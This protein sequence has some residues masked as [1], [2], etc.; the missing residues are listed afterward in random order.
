MRVYVASNLKHRNRWIDVLRETGVETSSRWLHMGESKDD[1]SFRADV[2]IKCVEDVKSS[3]ALV[4]Y[5]AEGDSMKGALVEIGIAF[6]SGIPVVICGDGP[7]DNSFFCHPLVS[8][9]VGPTMEH[10]LTVALALIGSE[11]AAE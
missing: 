4:Y 9:R 6:A 3:K 2:W 1:K 10:G 8:G 5:K 11:E 7:F